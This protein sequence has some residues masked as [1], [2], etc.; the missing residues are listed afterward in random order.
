VPKPKPAAKPLVLKAPPIESPAVPLPR[1]RPDSAPKP[2]QIQV[3]FEDG[4]PTDEVPQP[5]AA[6]Q[7][8]KPEVKDNAAIACNQIPADRT[9]DREVRTTNLCPNLPL[10]T[11][12]L[13]CVDNAKKQTLIR[14][15]KRT[16]G[17][18]SAVVAVA[19]IAGNVAGHFDDAD[20]RTK[21]IEPRLAQL[22]QEKLKNE[23]GGPKASTQSKA[24]V[25]PKAPAK[26]KVAGATCTKNEIVG[27]SLDAENKCRATILYCQNK[28][29][30]NLSLPSP[31]ADAS[32]CAGVKPAAPAAPLLAS[33]AL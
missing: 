5:A 14:I 16:D 3:P 28:K 30:Q 7:A 33:P 19:K 32:R 31:P 1:Q 13:E 27:Y 12:Y 22:A 25:Q 4:Y 20:W 23:C 26:E 11:V 9:P 17:Q 18:A 10:H 21:K 24:A 15:E 29:L 6:P 8:P 2:E